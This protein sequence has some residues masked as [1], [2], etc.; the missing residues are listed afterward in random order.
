MRNDAV[1]KELTNEVRE[2]KDTV[3]KLTCQVQKLQLKREAVKVP[4]VFE[5]GDTVIILSSGLIGKVGNKASV[6]S[7]GKRVRV[8][9]K[10]QHTNRAHR[11]LKHSH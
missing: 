8:K 7:I 11:N 3:Q 1:V 6:T 10:S 5:A 9:V 4:G 2:L